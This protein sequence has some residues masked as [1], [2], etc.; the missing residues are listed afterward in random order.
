MKNL[1]NFGFQELSAK[2]IRETDGGRIPWRKLKKW[3]G[4][5]M[6]W[7]GVYDAIDEFTTGFAEGNFE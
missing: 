4:K 1:E 7:A 5:L 2:E 6:E 3:G